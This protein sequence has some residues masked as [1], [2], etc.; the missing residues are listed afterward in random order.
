MSSVISASLPGDDLVQLV[1]VEERE[2]LILVVD[3]RH[4]FVERHA[5]DEEARPQHDV[6][7]GAVA[8]RDD[9]RLRQIPLRVLELCP[10]RLDLRLRCLHLCL[11]RGDLRFH[12]GDRG[13]LA[14][15]AAGELFANLLL[16]CARRRELRAELVDRG[17]RLLEVEA[18]TGAG[19]Y[20]LGVLLDA[21][22]RQLQ[23]RCERA[24]L[25]CR[26]IQLLV[27]LPLA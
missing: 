11:R 20:E 14:L 25:P 10:R 16:G 23:R 24:D 22:A 8:G 15:D 18:I 19:G 7:H 3:E 1:L 6:H 9:R 2:D 13:Q 17:L 26:L 12:L 27:Q 4:D 21:R 5:G